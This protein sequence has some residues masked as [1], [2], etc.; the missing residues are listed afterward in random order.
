MIITKDMQEFIGLLEKHK[1]PYAVVGGI[2]V[3]YY[4]NIR[5]TQDF[6]VLIFPS[7][8]T[9]KKMGKVLK[10][11]GFGGV[12]FSEKLFQQ[13]KSA[14]HL[15]VEPNRIDIL[16]SLE[17]ISN[18]EIL[19]NARKVVF[20][21][22]SFMMI[23]RDNLIACKR[24]SSRYKDLADVE[25]LESAGMEVTKKRSPPPESRKKKSKNKE[26]S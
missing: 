17:G 18:A 6:D 21:G 4:G 11:F 14:I 13:E 24:A 15:G 20:Q 1:V 23:S 26:A 2:A 3:I 25:Y 5:T 7:A 9:A 10:D 19:S 8:E 16:T 12:G 22:F